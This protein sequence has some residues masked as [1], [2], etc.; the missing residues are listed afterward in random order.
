MAAL[1]NLLEDAG[2]VGRVLADREEDR[3]RAMRGERVDHRHRALRPRAVVV[4]QH[5]LAGLEEV[6]LA[7][8]LE[9]EA[10]PAGGVDLDRARNAKR[11]RIAGAGLGAPRGAGRPAGG[12]ACAMVGGDDGGLGVAVRCATVGELSAAVGVATV[13]ASVPRSR[14][15]GLARLRGDR[16]RRGG[17]FPVQQRW[18]DGDQ[19]SKNAG[20]N[21]ER[22]R[23]SGYSHTHGS[24]PTLRRHH[25]ERRT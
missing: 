22:N 19:I 21:G 9:A 25:N 20:K 24:L 2:L 1:R 4:G 17:R 11:V 14:F 12:E 5:D 16:R 23:A 18:I 8:M 3:A 15:A 6:V 7:E 10:G 13:G